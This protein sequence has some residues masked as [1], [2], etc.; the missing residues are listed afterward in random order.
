MSPV[1]NSAKE[2][3]PAIVNFVCALFDFMHHYVVNH[4]DQTAITKAHCY[5]HCEQDD[6][7]C[8]EIGCTLGSG[9]RIVWHACGVLICFM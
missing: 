3:L 2:A 9:G 1:A 6:E 8:G 7:Q 5:V 4:S